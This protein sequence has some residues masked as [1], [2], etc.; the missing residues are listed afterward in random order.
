MPARIFW[1][2]EASPNRLALM[3]RPRSGDWL[4]DEVREWRDAGIDTVVSLLEPFEENELELGEERALCE[5]F[6]IEFLSFPIP[7][8]G[9]PTSLPEAKKLVDELVARLAAGK[10]VAIHCRVGIGRSGLITACVLVRLGM[11]FDNVF[12][13]LGRARGLPVPDTTE[14]VHWTKLFALN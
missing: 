10:A 9:V 2:Q 5:G 7:D 13:V 11:P 4:E 12:E 3:P 6:G 8:R 1:V 14:Q